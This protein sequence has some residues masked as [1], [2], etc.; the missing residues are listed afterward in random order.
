MDGESAHS[1]FIADAL[2]FLLRAAAS[3]AHAAICSASSTISSG[4]STVMSGD[5]AMKKSAV[6]IVYD[7]SRIG[8]A[9]LLDVY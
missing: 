4:T 7:P 1:F 9:K 2:P 3:L 8:Y 5:D 6:Q